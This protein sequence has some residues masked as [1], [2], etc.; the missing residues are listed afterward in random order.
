MLMMTV[1]QRISLFAKKICK[2]QK[3]KKEYASDV[4]LELQGWHAAQLIYK[5]K[6]EHW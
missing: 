5:Q 4:K 3:T 1:V 6:D 2:V